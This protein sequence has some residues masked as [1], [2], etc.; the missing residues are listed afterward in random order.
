[1]AGPVIKRGD[2]FGVKNLPA[3]IKALIELMAPPDDPMGGLTPSPVAPLVARGGPKMIPH[4]RKWGEALIQRAK[5]EGNMPLNT[6]LPADIVESL[7]FAQRRYPR[8]FGHLSS[9]ETLP[10]SARPLGRT[11]HP[12]AKHSRLQI[13]PNPGT[14]YFEQRAIEKNP[15]LFSGPAT[16]GHELLHVADNIT[17]PAMPEAYNASISLRPYGYRGSSFEYRAKNAGE[18]F[19]HKFHKAKRNQR[20]I[21]NFRKTFLEP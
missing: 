9:I 13:R 4:L 21:A 2:P 11:V 18:S 19:Y 15:E 17:M 12:S 1:M 20:A 16:V 10:E 7:E 6:A 8:I 3:P 5:Q 14:P